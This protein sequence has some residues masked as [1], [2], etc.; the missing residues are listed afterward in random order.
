MKNTLALDLSALLAHLHRLQHEDSAVDVHLSSSG[1]SH[2]RTILGLQPCD[3]PGKFALG[4]LIDTVAGDGTAERLLRE[5]AGGSTDVE[6][7]PMSSHLLSVTATASGHFAVA[8]RL[9]R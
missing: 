6:T 4:H 5:A 8:I 9:V 2:I 1:R 3:S 7:Y